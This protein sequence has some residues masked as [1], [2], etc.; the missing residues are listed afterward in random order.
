MLDHLYEIDSQLRLQS[1]NPDESFL[2]QAPA[3][4]GKTELLSQR[5]LSL[6]ANVNQPEEII[7]L[8]FT[9]KSAAE[10][11]HRIERA[12]IDAHE[13]NPVTQ[14]H[15]ELTR[16]L[17]LN[18][19]AHGKDWDL[20]A[21]TKRM[22]ITTL[23]SL[24]YR[25]CKS[26]PILSHAGGACHI[27]ESAHQL[28]QKAVK[29]LLKKADIPGIERLLLHVDN[30]LQTLEKLLIFM[31][32]K[33]EQWLP[34]ITI[35][36]EDKVHF[37]NFLEN[38]LRIIA[39]DFQEKIIDIMSLETIEKCF[40]IIH[41]ATQYIDDKKHA[42]HQINDQLDCKFKSKGWAALSNL[43]LTP[44]GTWRK[45]F[46]I[47]LGFN[48]DDP[49]STG[50]KSWLLDTID[51]HAHDN[52][53]IDLLIQIRILNEITYTEKQ[54][55]ILSDLVDILPYLVAQLHILFRN[56]QAVDFNEINLNAAYALKALDSNTDI[57]LYLNHAIKHILV[58][59]FQDTSNLHFEI[60]ETLVSQWEP[61]EKR[62]LFFVGDPQQSIYRFRQANVGLFLKLKKEGIGDYY[63]QYICLRKNFRSDKKLVD[64]FNRYFKSIFGY[65]ENI[66]LGIVSYQESISKISNND[67]SGIHLHGI[68]E[69][70]TF[71]NQ[72]LKTI[73][74]CK[75]GSTAIL[76]RSRNHL[77]EIIECLQQAG[78]P[79]QAH[80]MEKLSQSKVIEDLTALTLALHQPGNRMLWT[81]VLRAPWCGLR[82]DD[83]L[84]LSEYEPKKSIFYALQ[85]LDAINLSMDGQ[86]RLKCIAP[87]L[88]YAV[89]NVNKNSLKCW[90]EST[91]RSLKGHH[92]ISQSA[93]YENCLLFFSALD[94]L[95]TE[96]ITN[97]S[98]V[99]QLNHTHSQIE[100][101]PVNSIQIMTIHKS[102]GLEFNHVI[103]THL[104]K[105]SGK[106][107]S[108]L[109]RWDSIMTNDSQHIIF[110]P[111]QATGKDDDPIYSL[112]KYR[113]NKKNEF[114]N[115]RLLYVAMT[116]ARHN[117]HLIYELKKNNSGKSEYKDPPKNSFLYLLYQAYPDDFST[118]MNVSQTKSTNLLKERT[119]SLPY[120]RLKIKHVG[121]CIQ[122]KSEANEL[123]NPNDYVENFLNYE[124]KQLGQLIH[125]ALETISIKGIEFWNS[126][127][128]KESS[129]KWKYFLRQNGLENYLVNTLTNMCIRCLNEILQDPKAQWILS[130]KHREAY[131][132]YAISYIKNGHHKKVIIDR[133]FI[134]NNTFW[135]IDY[136]CGTPKNDESEIDF[137]GKQAHIH[138][139]Q[140]IKYRNI[141]KKITTKHIEL[142]LYFPLLQ[143][144]YQYDLQQ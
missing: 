42:F 136:K 90:V 13:N 123:I 127:K 83:L 24:S 115:K 8:S 86:N 2:V 32:V 5:Y 122:T 49:K 38:N 99:E 31:L 87:I 33:R 131:S 91:W 113:E 126:I 95:S 124:Q 35:N 14:P 44:A 23:D 67:G 125:F 81:A 108:S 130:S 139:Q 71:A 141:L 22:Q 47:R 137:I 119:S 65:Q 132:E 133:C 28:Y 89:R 68:G 106:D 10:M 37:R 70:T 39:N 20:I 92:L 110:A 48:K 61:E 63:L 53:L 142:A 62:S 101:Q 94:Q 4:S 79:Y 103:L 41:Y 36:K 85:H 56:H 45:Q 109:L 1:L 26:I 6:L 3:G 58:D 118:E 138:Q 12:L 21:N 77:P 34:F 30:N 84:T 134:D 74:L 59:E 17:A 7:A 27:K 16:K 54:W 64:Q 25:I 76:I 11:K 140:L 57:A 66:D 102:K 46:N 121:N 75:N 52:A 50:D 120:H 135:I 93:D 116:R 88:N 98:L 129:E 112:I 29:Q 15:L 9:K 40:S 18:A 100:T 144:W 80:E 143:Q 51:Q 117:L 43:L 69:N 107:P 82:L 19:L 104:E 128:I 111:I 97:E 78:I 55:E 114:E 72:L 73:N 60:I 96:I 105:N